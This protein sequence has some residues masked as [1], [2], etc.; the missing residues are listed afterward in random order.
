[1]SRKGT[2]QVVSEHLI[3]LAYDIAIRLQDFFHKIRIPNNFLIHLTFKTYHQKSFSYL[4]KAKEHDHMMYDE[5]H[6]VDVMGSFFKL[7]PFYLFLGYPWHTIGSSLLTLSQRIT[8]QSSFPKKLAHQFKLQCHSSNPPK[9]H[10]LFQFAKTPSSTT[11][12]S[13]T[14]LNLPSKVLDSF[15]IIM[16]H[17]FMFF[18]PKT[19]N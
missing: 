6:N 7:E 11:S 15:P 19:Q 3:L 10:S 18:S 16:H 17:S 5:S 13:K 12:A 14:R 8:L 9:V 4:I 2:L 1:M